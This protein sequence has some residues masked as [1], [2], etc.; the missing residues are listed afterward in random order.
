MS[1]SK[2]DILDR[3][4]QIV[5]AAMCGDNDYLIQALELYDTYM[6]TR[7]PNESGVF[8]QKFSINGKPKVQEKIV[9]NCSVVLTPLPNHILKQYI[10]KKSTG[11]E[12]DQQ[13]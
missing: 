6:R 10:Q 7:V 12:M 9:K 3:L 4:D 11:S 13:H 1:E 5:E 8:T 2:Q